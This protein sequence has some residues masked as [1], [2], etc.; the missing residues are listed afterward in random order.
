MHKVIINNLMTEKAAYFLKEEITRL[1]PIVD[2][3]VEVYTEPEIKPLNE[4]IEDLEAARKSEGCC[5]KC[6]NN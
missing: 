2:G 6:K 5:G 3:N 1:F 4:V